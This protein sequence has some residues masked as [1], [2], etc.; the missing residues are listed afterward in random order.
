MAMLND[1]NGGPGM[2]IDMDNAVDMKCEKCGCNTFKGTNLIKT[3]S[4]I[5]SPSGK[6]MIIPIPVF[7]CENCG[8]VN[9]EFLKNEFE[10]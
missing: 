2:H 1:P 8:H 7:A 4:A 10:E 9:K 6:E 3:I 5:V